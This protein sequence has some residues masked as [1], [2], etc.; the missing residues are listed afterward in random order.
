MFNDLREF[1]KQAE[2]LGEFRKVEG[3]DWDLEIGAITELGT[4]V[5]VPPLLLFDNIKEYTQGY[6]I[7]S[8]V[9]CSP[10]RTALCWG[11]PFNISG[12]EQ[13]RALRDKLSEQFSPLPPTIVNTGPV[14]ENI[15]TGD[16][17]DIFEFPI[18]RW[19]QLDGGRYLGTGDMVIQ[20]DPD[21]GWVNLGTYRVQIQD[22]A[23]AT[24]HI[25]NGHH[26]DIIAKKYW[27]RGLSCPTAVVCG[28]DPLLWT[29]ASTAVPREVS[30][31]DYAGWLRNRPIDVVRG[32]T[33]D[34][35]IPATA[36]IVLEGE[37]ISPEIETRM[38]GPFGEWEGYYAGGRRPHPVFRVKAILHRDNPIIYGAPPLV[39]PFEYDHGKHILRSAELWRELDRQLPG[40]K[41]VWYV[42]EAKAPQ[43][44]IISI[45]QQYPGHAKQAAMAAA[46][47]YRGLQLGR[48]LIIVDDDIDPSNIA[49]VLWAVSTRCD[50]ET[51]IDIIAGCTGLASD[52]RLSPEKR[53]RGDFVYSRAFIYACKPYAWIK[54]F[55]IS[56]KS[57]PEDLEQVRRKWGELL[58][59]EN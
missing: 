44:G 29:L 35:P 14:K 1:I 12:T 45:K 48:F 22:K 11:L 49:E 38:E 52:P 39:G 58:Y 4:H 42:N 17:V 20:K 13:V 59:G 37:F 16:E 41:G 40:V 54:E 8:N 9:L 43:M 46:G 28:Q 34:L 32:E 51:S 3:A 23:T 53:E 56:I 57:S 55:P 26:G 10:K 5:Q 36:E 30:E 19:H 33:V 21:T 6:R 50:P 2:E 15:H 31:Y 24:I 18:P 25:V 7:A 27:E 47:C